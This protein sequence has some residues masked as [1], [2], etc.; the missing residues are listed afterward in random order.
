M[1]ISV[2]D[3][4]WNALDRV[5][6]K[7]LIIGVICFSLRIIIWEWNP[8]D[9]IIRHVIEALIT[10]TNIWSWIIAIFGYGAKHLNK[11][12]PLLKYC[13]LSLIHI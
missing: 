4:L 13:N 5:K 8:E 7:A 6:S 10:V 1:L 12:S 11:P 9:G 2:K 3:V